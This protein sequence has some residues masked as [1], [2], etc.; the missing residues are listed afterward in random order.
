MIYS[1]WE[2]QVAFKLVWKVE[3]ECIRSVRNRQAHVVRSG[4]VMRVISCRVFDTSITT[5]TATSHREILIRLQDIQR[6]SRVRVS[7]LE[8]FIVK[9]GKLPAI[10]GVN[11]LQC[12][13]L[14]SLR[15]LVLIPVVRKEHPFAVVCVR[16]G[17][18]PESVGHFVRKLDDAVSWDLCAS[19]LC[20]SSSVCYSPLVSYPSSISI[21]SNTRT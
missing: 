18:V 1:L 5:I 4:L 7:T 2:A 6:Q 20:V 13:L 15:R 17:G 14:E 3:F 9:L 21:F 19:V 11:H 8:R 12:G 10:E 16:R